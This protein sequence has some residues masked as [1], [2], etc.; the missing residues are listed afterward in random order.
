MGPTPALARQLLERSR[1]LRVLPGRRW[2]RQRRRCRRRQRRQLAPA[3]LRP[4]ELRV[5]KRRA[6]R[7]AVDREH[8]AE[9]RRAGR[10]AAQHRAVALG[11]CLRD[12]RLELL[13]PALG[14]AAGE[15]EG[16]P[17]TEHLAAL[18]TEPVRCLAHDMTLARRKSRRQCHRP[19]P[20]QAGRG[21]ATGSESR[22]RQPTLQSLVRGASAPTDSEARR[23]RSRA[24]LPPAGPGAARG[25]R[26]DR[27]R[28]GRGT[29]TSGSC[30][31]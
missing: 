22:P 9:G 3:D 25:R 12:L 23:A 4:E 18:F 11:T 28:T 17:V 24:R 14:V 5:A 27:A 15:T 1:R 16:D 13:E 6:A 2:R 10:A 21:T 8:R 31:R 29:G 7:L 19:T 30:G 26:K 20:R